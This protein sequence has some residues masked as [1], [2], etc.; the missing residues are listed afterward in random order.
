MVTEARRAGMLGAEEAAN[1]TE[2]PNIRQKG[3]KDGEL[4]H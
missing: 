2:V 4:A 3:T 1:L